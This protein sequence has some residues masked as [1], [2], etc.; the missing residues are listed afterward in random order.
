MVKGFI[1]LTKASSWKMFSKRKLGA[2][3]DLTVMSSS[4]EIRG[5]GVWVLYVKI[6]P[7]GMRLVPE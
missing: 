3:S 4:V 1:S 2:L 5:Q 7:R 6:E